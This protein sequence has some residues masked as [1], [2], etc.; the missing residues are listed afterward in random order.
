[1]NLDATAPAKLSNHLTVCSRTPLQLTRGNEGRLSKREPPV[2]F[3]QA[4][5]PQ[6][7]S[8]SVSRQRSRGGAGVPARSVDL[9]Q[10]SLFL[11]WRQADRRS[12][13]RPEAHATNPPRALQT[14]PL[15]KGERPAGMLIAFRKKRY[16]AGGRGQPGWATRSNPRRLTA[17][18][19]S[20]KPIA[21]GE[22]CVRGAERDLVIQEA[23]YNGTPELSR[24]PEALGTVQTINLAKHGDC[25]HGRF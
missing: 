22:S 9:G 11:S 1:V 4:A 24:S 10:R 8:G 17:P 5:R 16:A 12:S 7:R 13:Q 6:R 25:L 20:Y 18:L 19:A 15:P 21:L 14:D 3:G 2:F 23:A